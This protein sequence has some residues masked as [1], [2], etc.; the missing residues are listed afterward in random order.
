M[1]TRSRLWWTTVALSVIA[2]GHLLN[3][4]WMLAAPRHWYETIP[5]VTDFGPFNAHFVRDA[6][7]VY[8]TAGLALAW[9]AF[10]SRY[11]LPLVAVVAVFHGAHSV[12]HIHDTLGEH[13]S[14]HHWWIDFPGV[15]LP[16]LVLTAILIA[17]RPSRA[18]SG[19]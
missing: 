4:A 9:A 3:A 13:V 14:S 11:R 6:G 2:A 8:L 18:G 16:A 17:I 12:L 7:C 1:N 19:T 15:Y 5:G 10:A